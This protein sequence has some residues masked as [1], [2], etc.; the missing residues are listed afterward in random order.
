MG[1]FNKVLVANRGEIARRIFR[2][3]KSLGIQTVAVY[4]EI[5]EGTPFVKEADENYLLGPAPVT[6]SYLNIE[7]IIDIAIEANVDAIHPGYGFLAEN[8][9]FARR[10]QEEGIVFIGP[11]PE[12]IEK[13]GSKIKSRKL[14]KQ[15]GVPVV[16]GCDHAID[17]LEN[18]LTIAEE[19]GYPLI[20]KASAGGGGIGMQIIH[21][22]EELQRNFV[23]IQKRAENYFGNGDVFLEKWIE[24]PRHIELQVARDEHGNSLH[25]FERECSI[26]R[27]H[28]KVIEESP[29]PFLTEESRAK[30]IEAALRGVEAIKYNNVGTMEFIFDNTGNFYFLEMNTR[31]QVEHPI[32]EEVTGLDIVKMQLEIS[33]GKP[34]SISQQQIHSNGHSL[35]CRLYAED[36]KTFL[37]SP[38]KIKKLS[39]PK[40]DGR[41][42]LAVEEGNTVSHYYDPMIGKIIMT[43]ATRDESIEKMISTLNSIEIDGLK[44]NLQLLTE[45]CRNQLFK[46]GEYNTHFIQDEILNK[47]N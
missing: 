6:Q 1:L 47:N 14:M 42:E 37:P 4:S 18:G 24:S 7:K 43:G 38:G 44:T 23:N 15:A 17:S 41:F 12:I 19:I 36:P 45:V 11:S 8:A 16:P 13:M 33:S 21:N 29:S 34:F 26:Q 40:I 30:L 28:Q 2:T 20:L 39:I 5:D 27:R 10:C 46:S 9:N 22:E 31:I 25:L 3:C 32:T 35:E